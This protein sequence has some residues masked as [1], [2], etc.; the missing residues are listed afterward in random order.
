MLVYGTLHDTLNS[1]QFIIDEPA[2]QRCSL[3]FIID[4]PSDVVLN[5]HFHY[6]EMKK[7]INESGPY[8]FYVAQ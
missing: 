7:Q 6:C 2:F 3:Q 8:F 1:L 4:E 5:F